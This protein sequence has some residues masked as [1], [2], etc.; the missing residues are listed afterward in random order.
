VA[1]T[2]TGQPYAGN[3]TVFE[4]TYSYQVTPWWTLQP[5]L[6]IVINPGAG[7]PSAFSST[8]LKNDVIGG[9]RAT[10]VF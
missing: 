10:I 8:S 3:E 2:G 6:Q 4:A 9:V 7:I 1:F 5:D